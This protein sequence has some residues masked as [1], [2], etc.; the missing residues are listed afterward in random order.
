VAWCLQH[1]EAYA[2]EFENVAI[3]KRSKRERRFSRC[4]EIDRRA[5]AIA[6]LQMSGNEIGVEM[7]QE[8]VLD[9]ERVFKA[10]VTKQHF[11]QQ[12]FCELSLRQ[13]VRFL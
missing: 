10:T 12:L 6:Q 3:V 5:R 13:V 8:Y 4:T 11:C 2:S 1:L 7:R 9:I